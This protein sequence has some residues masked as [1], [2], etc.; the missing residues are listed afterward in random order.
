M[1]EATNYQ[2]QL[3]SLGGL[4]KVVKD[5]FVNSGIKNKHARPYILR[6]S[7]TTHVA[8]HRF[9]HAQMCKM[10]GWSVNSKNPSKYIHMSGIRLDDSIISL[11]EGGK[12][13][14]QE[15]K[16]KTISCTRCSDKISPGANYCR[17]CALPVK[18]LEE[19][20]HEVDLKEENRIL[21]ERVDLMEQK[22]TAIHESQ[23][24][25]TDLLTEPEKLMA[26]FNGK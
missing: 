7:R 1:S 16:L 19:Y 6:H 22:M 17:T 26:V 23:K 9:E 15:Y 18:F 25:F 8:S 21:K 2:N 5:A 24:E 11:S 20:T 4:N 12:V 3:L 14:P 10:F 13:Q